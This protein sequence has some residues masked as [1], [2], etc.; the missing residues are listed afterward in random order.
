[1]N[2]YII[3]CRK[4]SESEERQVLSIESQIKELKETAA[5]LKLEVSEILT[6]SRSAKKP[7][8]PVFNDM[9]SRLYKGQFKGVIAWKL[10]R[11]AR[12]PIDG[13]SLIWALDQGHISGIITPHGTFSNDS[14][15]KLMMQIEF[16]MAKKY[17]DDLS[18]NVKRG[19]RAKL[20][21]GWLP[22]PAPVGY[23]NE[24]VEKTII[25]DPE[26]FPLVRKMWE[27]LLQGVKPDRILDIATNEWGFRTRKQR[28]RGGEALGR[29][30]LYRLF[31]SPFYYGLIQRKEG[32]FIGKHPPMI[33]EDE[34]WRAQAILGRKGKPRP[35]RHSFS[36]TGLIRCAECGC[37]ITA[38]E[39]TK[40]SG[41]H[42]VY[43]RCTKKRKHN[44]RCSQKYVN[45]SDLENQIVD[46]LARIRVFPPLLDLTVTY[47]KEEEKEEEKR[48]LPVR[49][50]LEQAL[51]HCQS[52]LDKLTRMRLND[53]MSDDEYL[54]E[55]RRLLDEKI[56]LTERLKNDDA[57]KINPVASTVETFIFAG[58][59]LDRFR[60]GSP[61]DKRNVLQQIG[62]NFHLD[63]GKLVIK[64]EKP[65]LI[66]E[67]GLKAVC[68]DFNWLELPI[69]GLVMGKNALYCSAIP[70]WR[71][72]V[73]DVRTF[74]ENKLSRENQKTAA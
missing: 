36:F 8:R 28:K 34:F 9:M 64:A 26:R 38:E 73:D 51:S 24:P 69:N 17:V 12:N 15:A 40:K 19:N 59:A 41:L 72:V 42:Y 47:L 70:D 29:T 4:S 18:D 48:H 65:L 30:S 20:E 25:K 67:E 21:K 1:M 60:N 53:L 49:H 33:S 37:M 46:S 55:K 2:N 66:I 58:Q 14:N 13:A 68:T 45:A 27:M 44:E 43:Y 10:D 54:R 35:K 50:S 5:R 16:G 52:Q 74:F 57:G 7:G 63:D 62:S 22:S 71:A 11:L 31:S 3:Y 61:E 32:V 6:E 23:M 56:A 39:K